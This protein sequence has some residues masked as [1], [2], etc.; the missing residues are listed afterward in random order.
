[1]IDKDQFQKKFPFITCVKTSDNE[2]LGIV[3]NYDASVISIYSYADIKTEQE[4]KL[5]LEMGEIWWWESNRKIPISIFLKQDMVIFRP[6]I[7]TFNI[8]DA[9]IEFGPVVNL[10][11]IAGKRVK[12]KSIQLVRNPKKTRN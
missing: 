1:M 8:K 4:K 11:D 6:Y 10:G 9:E 2:Y 7:K 12:R 3:I 5:F